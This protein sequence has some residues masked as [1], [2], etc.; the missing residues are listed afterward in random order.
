[1]IGQNVSWGSTNMLYKR[2]SC[3]SHLVKFLERVTK[4]SDKAVTVD[5]T[6]QFP[7]GL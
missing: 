7:K 5:N 4:H 3:F 2:K 1:M 6:D